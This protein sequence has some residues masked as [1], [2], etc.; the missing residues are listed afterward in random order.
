MSDWESKGKEMA[1]AFECRIRILQALAA[2]EKA[3]IAKERGWQ[4]SDQRLLFVLLSRSPGEG[5]IGGTAKECTYTV[6]YTQEMIAEVVE[7]RPWL[8]EELMTELNGGP[9]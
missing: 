4:P 8:I 5:N 7:N 3:K 2:A 9:Q 6:F 1:G